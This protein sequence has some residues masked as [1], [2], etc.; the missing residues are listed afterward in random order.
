MFMY[1]IHDHCIIRNLVDILMRIQMV[2][3]KLNCNESHSFF[4]RILFILIGTKYGKKKKAETNMIKSRPLSRD[5]VKSR[6]KGL[7]F[8]LKIVNAVPYNSLYSILLR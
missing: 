6:L 1:V 8:L 7:N 2:A 4:C 3:Q 5:F